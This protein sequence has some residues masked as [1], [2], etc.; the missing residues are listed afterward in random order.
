MTHRSPS[1]KDFA[2]TALAMAIPLNSMCTMS[3][4]TAGQRGSEASQ[5]AWMDLADKLHAVCA[6]LADGSDPRE[7]LYALADLT[8][9]MGALAQQE[10]ANV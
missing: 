9:K 7:A 8:R 4:V 6:A 10:A 3:I 5:K 1:D 2:I